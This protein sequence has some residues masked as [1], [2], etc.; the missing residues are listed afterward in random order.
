MHLKSH[1]VKK[2]KQNQEEEA[3]AVASVLGNFHS[4]GLQSHITFHHLH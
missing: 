3:E 1:Q 2:L 4:V